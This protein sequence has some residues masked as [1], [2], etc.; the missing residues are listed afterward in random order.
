[1]VISWL[2]K[3][4]GMTLKEAFQHTKARRRVIMPNEGAAPSLP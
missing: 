4:N 1:V 3:Y 2:I